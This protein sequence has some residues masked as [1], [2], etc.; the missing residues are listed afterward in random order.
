[1]EIDVDINSFVHICETHLLLS[2]RMLLY[3][4]DEYTAL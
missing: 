4:C 2:A 3:I 1:M